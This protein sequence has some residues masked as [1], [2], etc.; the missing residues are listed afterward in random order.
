MIRRLLERSGL[1]IH[2]KK[3]YYAAETRLHLSRYASLFGQ[4]IRPGNLVFDVGANLGQKTQIF[5]S[6]GARVISIEPE[7][8]CTEYLQ[9]KFRGVD[10]VTVVNVAVSDEPGRL[11][12]Y[13]SPQTPRFPRSIP[14]GSPRGPTRTKQDVWRHSPWTS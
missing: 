12:L 13:V 9:K 5:L 8:G 10:R 11:Q 6:L 7:R 2:V 14:R 1:L 3:I 4:V